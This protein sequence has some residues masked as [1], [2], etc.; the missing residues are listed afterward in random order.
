MI[1]L[2]TSVNQLFLFYKS[3]F[4]SLDWETDTMAVGYWGLL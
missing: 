2:P 4:F 1:Y 3:L